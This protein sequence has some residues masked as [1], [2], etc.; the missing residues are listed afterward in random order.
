M[1]ARLLEQSGRAA[2]NLRDGQVGHG[3]AEF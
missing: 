1:F 3:A 2:S